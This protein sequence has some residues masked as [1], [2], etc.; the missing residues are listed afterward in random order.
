MLRL[1][2]SVAGVV[3]AGGP[4]VFFVWHELSEALLG[5]PNGA[6]LALAALFLLL[7]AGVLSRFARY[8]QDLEARGREGRREDGLLTQS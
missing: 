5:R 7:L 4:L 2:L 6:R 8:L 3:V 1:V